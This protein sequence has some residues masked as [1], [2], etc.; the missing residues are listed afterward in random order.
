MKGGGK[1]DLITVTQPA[2]P[3]RLGGFNLI[4]KGEVVQRL[5]PAWALAAQDGLR[6]VPG[7]GGPGVR[8]QLGAT[9]A[10]HLGCWV[11]GMDGVL[12]LS[13]Q[14][15]PWEHSVFSC[16]FWRCWD[17]GREMVW[18]A[19]TGLVSFSVGVLGTWESSGLVRSKC[20]VWR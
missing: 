8:Q 4:W 5:P 13:L 6:V 9:L 12:S 19:V 3:Q 1:S 11:L 14:K 15:S 7:T 20:T 16:L 17:P 10:A 2:W 18:L